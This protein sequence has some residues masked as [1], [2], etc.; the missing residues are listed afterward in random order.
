MRIEFKP[1]AAKDLDALDRQTARRV[2]DKIRGLWKTIW[3]A[4]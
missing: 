1:R 2:L 3:R 4:T